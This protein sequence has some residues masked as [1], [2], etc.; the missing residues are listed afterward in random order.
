MN[1][2]DIITGILAGLA[3]YYIYQASGLWNG[4]MVLIFI[5][6]VATWTRSWQGLWE[7]AVNIKAPHFMALALLMIGFTY[8]SL[9]G[10][11]FLPSNI[12][13]IGTAMIGFAIGIV[14]Y[15]LWNMP[16]R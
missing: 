2:I 16:G 15:G 4:A 6:V 7:L 13:S 8:Y 5:A 14:I 11:G 3:A 12:F 1:T 10:G 9:E